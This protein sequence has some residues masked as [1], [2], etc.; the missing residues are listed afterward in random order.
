MEKES[1]GTGTS[2]RRD[3]LKYGGAV[4]GAGLLAGC[5]GSGAGGAGTTTHTETDAET[6]S[7]TTTHT[8]TDAE[9]ASETTT[10]T[11]TA[12]D[13]SYSVTMSPMGTVEFESVPETA[14]SFDDQWVDHMIALGQG[15]KLVGLARPAGYF[16]AFYDR[17]PGVSFD[18]SDVT[19]I[20][21]NEAVDMEILFELDAD[22]HHIDPIR[23]LDLPG[24][25][26]QNVETI[27]KEVGPFFANRGSRAHNV[28][29]GRDIDYEFYTLWEITSKFAEVYQVQDRSAALKAVRDEMVN[30][31][32]SKLP[33]EDERP[34]VGLLL[35]WDGKIWV[36][37]PNAPGFGKAH[38][39]PVRLKDA[40]S[41]VPGYAES[42]WQGGKISV[43]KALDADPDVWIQHNAVGSPDWFE[44][45]VVPALKDDPVASQITAVRNDRI[46]PGGTGLGGPLFNLFQIEMTAKQVYPDLFGEYPGLREPVPEDEQLFD[47]QR[48][49]DIVNGDV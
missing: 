26:E 46:Y 1:T 6:A 7:E 34:S 48:V 17:L 2:T 5:A 9:T 27:R 43:E 28:P 21:S 12:A 23:A 8:E 36:Y 24:L 15:D 38:Y 19:A 44:N 47:R 18:K 37:D 49:S 33:P 42:N 4:V 20:W 29:G 32:Q 31:I 11:E 40:L 25:D 13:T 3:C 22:V 41:D 10:H 14:V 35:W 45:T 30:R 16:T 39:R